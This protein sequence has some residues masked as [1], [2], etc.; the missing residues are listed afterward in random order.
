MA[1]AALAENRRSPVFQQLKVLA[2][3]MQALTWLAYTGPSC[4]EYVL[5]HT[6]QYSCLKA[7]VQLKLQA[8]L[9]VLHAQSRS[10]QDS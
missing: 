6:Q 8:I 7:C 3:G 1:A 2:E 5:R 4:G 9:T 10:L